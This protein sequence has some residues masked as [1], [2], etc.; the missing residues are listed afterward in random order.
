M[1]T[2]VEIKSN[3]LESIETDDCGGGMPWDLITLK[4]GTV[5]VITEDAVGVYP[6]RDAFMQG[7]DTGKIVEVF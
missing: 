7:D 6:S 1:K 2:N 4:S 3:F 5:L